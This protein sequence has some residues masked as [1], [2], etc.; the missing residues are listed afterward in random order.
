[1]PSGADDVATPEE[2]TQDVDPAYVTDTGSVPLK[3]QPLPLAA[4]GDREEEYFRARLAGGRMVRV[5]FQ[6]EPPT[7]A[8]IGKLI[9]LLELSKDQ[10]PAG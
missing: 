8:E 3:G 5:L 4:L 7:Q 2:D 1:M 10:Y 9:A 6:G